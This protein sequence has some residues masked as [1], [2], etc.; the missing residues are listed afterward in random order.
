MVPVVVVRFSVYIV[1]KP[2]GFEVASVHK[3][4]KTSYRV[5]V[6]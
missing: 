1:V 3:Q 6:S 2:G 5:D 4:G